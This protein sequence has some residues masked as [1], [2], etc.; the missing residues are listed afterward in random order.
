MSQD[1]LKYYGRYILSNV[2]LCSKVVFEIWRAYLTVI[3]YTRAVRE[4]RRSLLN[5]DIILSFFEISRVTL[6]N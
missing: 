4:V 5:I 1:R 3:R 6:L 2:S